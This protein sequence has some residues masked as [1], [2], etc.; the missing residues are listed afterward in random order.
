MPDYPVLTRK[1]HTD[2]S[3]LACM[4]LLLAEPAAFYPQ[5]ATHNAQSI[6]SVSVIAPGTGAYE[7]QRLHGMGEA[8]YEEVVGEGKLGAQCRIYAPVGPHADLVAY[9]VRRLLENGANTSFINRLAD[10][11]APIADI[12][13][14]PVA[15]VEAEKERRAPLRILPRPQEIYAPERINSRGMALDQP[16]VR[17]ALLKEIAADLQ[18]EIAAAPLV[19]GKVEAGTGAEEPVLSPHDRRQR[20]GSVRVADAAAI[21][22]AIKAARGRRRTAGTGWAGRRGPPSWSAPPTSTSAT[23]CG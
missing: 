6:A 19:G 14:D 2:V 1:V 12:V 13:K 5:F 10:E 9:L 21:E 16:T 3:Y 4:R 18:T 23:A 11:E 17:A 7:F 8:L 20:V 22:T 15:G